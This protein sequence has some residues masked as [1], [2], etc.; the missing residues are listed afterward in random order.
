MK[1]LF[2]VGMAVFSVVVMVFFGVLTGRQFL[3]LLS[4]PERADNVS[5]GQMEGQYITYRVARPVASFVEEYYSGDPDRV[6][7]MA[8][9]VYEEESRIFLKVIVPEQKKGEFNRLL[10]AVNRSPELKESWGDMQEDEERPIEVTASLMPIEESG[11]IRQIE[12]ALA[13][14]ESYSTEEMNELARTQADW[15][16]LEYRTVGGISVSHLWICAVAEVLSLV[17]LLICLIFLAKKSE[18]STV[19]VRAGDT[20]GQFLEKQK[21]WLAPWCE[22]S[23]KWQNRIAVLILAGL[24]AG[25]TALGLFVGYTVQEVM[26]CHLPIGIILGDLST[27]VMLLG[28][29]VNCNPDRI[30]KNCRKS[31]ERTL[32]GQIEQAARELMDTSQEWAVVEMDKEDIEYGI[33]GENYWMILTGKGAAAVAEAGRVGK[34][35]SETVTGQMRSG[36]IRMNY[37]YYT[38][39]ISYM[40][41]KKKKGADV[42]FN[43]DGQETAGHFMM[44]VRKRLGERA[45]D[46]IK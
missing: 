43:F 27:I 41:S 20:V 6:R 8:Y 44:L 29:R 39:Q 16:V 36:K 46:I 11:Q 17:I 15:Y 28:V 18:E 42:T 4:G 33:V 35:T 3:S 5:P 7:R 1:K 31:L 10:Q 38:V 22:K 24:I 26:T 21:S 25:L 9:V 45:A 19:D 32:P 12:E 23:R 40:D 30:L 13:G 34:V 14:D 37:T 2:Y